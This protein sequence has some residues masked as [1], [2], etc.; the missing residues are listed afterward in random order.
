[1][2]DESRQNPAQQTGNGAYEQN[3][4][5]TRGFSRKGAEPQRKDRKKP[6]LLASGWKAEPYPV[7]FFCA[8]ATLRLGVS[9]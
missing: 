9:P 8:L 1:L 5:N 3:R 7:A 4:T 6:D 2:V